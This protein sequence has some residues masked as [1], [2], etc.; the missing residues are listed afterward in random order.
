MDIFLIRHGESEADILGVHEGR[1]DFHLTSKGVR[2]G[3]AMAAWMKNN[4]P[5]DCIWSSPLNRAKETAEILSKVTKIEINYADELM[6]FNNGLI[7]GLSIEEANRLF[8]EPK[9]KYPHTKIYNMESSIEFR[10]RAETILSKII[11]ENSK[12]AKIAIISHG[13][14]INML[15]RSFL[16]LPLESN[17]IFPTEDT[18]IHHWII[19]NENKYIISANT[20]EHIKN[21]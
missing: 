4:H 19:K 17:I 1:A 3:Q 7:A 2:Q 9:V 20:F 18:G 12:D 14:T 15:F 10:M 16:Q 8:P 21:I 5:I 13:G 6:E 11:N